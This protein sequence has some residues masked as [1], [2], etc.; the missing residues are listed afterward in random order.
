MSGRVLHLL[1]HGNVI[2]V[3]I[4]L[5]YCRCTIHASLKSGALSEV[6]TSRLVTAVFI[7]RNVL[8][9]C[10]VDNNSSTYSVIASAETFRCTV[11]NH[12][13]RESVRLVLV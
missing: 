2:V 6:T 9:L 7:G 10:D 8:P 11:V 4:L 3:E 13:V 1:S 12:S 5:R